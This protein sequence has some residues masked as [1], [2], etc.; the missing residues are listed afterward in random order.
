MTRRLLGLVLLLAGASPAAAQSR[1]QFLPRFDFH[2]AAN[3]LSGDDERFVWDA[4]L[5]GDLDFVDY[6]RGR[7][8]FAGNFEAVLGEEYHIFD[9]NQGNY[10]LDS[11]TSLRAGGVEFAAIFHHVSRHLSDRFKEIPVDWNMFGVDVEHETHP[12]GMTLRS[13]GQL[14]GVLLKSNVDYNWE[15]TSG[16]DLMAPVSPHIGLI[17]GGGVR[18]VGVDETRSRSTQVGG[19]VEGGV[20]FEGAAGSLEVVV[21]AERRIDAYPLDDEPRSWV[22]A[23]FRFVSR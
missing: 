15:S 8:R 16:V 17:T 1:V 6:G 2:L 4:N 21:A 9:P 19:R 14:F 3:H 11:S 7:L 5:G 12:A 23:G 13:R 20:R 22:S 10:Q 18:V